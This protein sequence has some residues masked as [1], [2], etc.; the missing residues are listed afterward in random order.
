MRE[1]PK[2]SLVDTVVDGRYHVRS[3]LASGGMSTVYLATDERLER[4]VALKVLYPHLAEDERFLE[5][6]EREAKSAA[7]LSHPH[8]VGVLD[9]GVEDGPGQSVAY[10]VMEYVP[11]KTL[12][13]LLTERGR[14]TPR[15]ALAILDPVV[16]GLGAAHDAGLIH[17]DVK[18]ENVLLSERGGIKIADFGLARA[19]SAA[20]HT[21]TLVGTA[22]YFPPE[23]VT[24]GAADAR[25]DIYSAGI[26]LFEL[27][28]GRQPYSGEAP[29]QVAFQH[30][31]S[32]VPA[33]STIVPGLAEDL[34]ELVLWC[35]A[36]D[37]EERPIDGNALLGELRHI[38]TNLRDD[39]LD[40][41][42]DHRAGS[43]P[44]GGEAAASDGA[45]R[46]EIIGTAH[47]STDVAGSHPYPTEVIG[48]SGS[49]TTVLGNSSHHTTV[50]GSTPVAGS[51]PQ[52]QLDSAA[53]EKL[54]ARDFKTYRKEQARA[55]QRPEKTLRP[56][57]AR[58]RNAFLI[59]LL[60]LL[61]ALAAI[62]GWFFGVGPGALVAVPDVSSRSVSAAQAL[63]AQ[64]GLSSS[65][66]QSY[67]DSV[68]EGLVIASEPE[69]TATVRPWE[70]IQLLVSLGPELF[71]IPEVVGLAEATAAAT[72]VAAGFEV[73]EVTPQFSDT[74]ADGA[75]IATTPAAG[76]QVPAGTPVSLTVSRGP[77]PVSV[78][79]VVG[80][81]EEEAVSILASAGLTPVIEPAPVNDINVPAGSV[82][83][84]T[85][86]EGQLPPGGSVT[87]TL[88]DGPRIIAVPDVFS[89]REAEAI[90]ALE[91][92]GFT[93]KVNYAFGRPVLGLVAGQDL[94]GE[95]PEG[96]TVTI[97]VT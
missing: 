90:A 80:L 35:T 95:H 84:Q 6:F 46:T 54:A 36:V 94:T 33:P 77:E 82:L 22:A 61:A 89:E 52:R 76:E 72:L 60:A 20:T 32:R 28:T 68:A 85:P 13:D 97:T 4:D 16:E 45:E 18:P 23:L 5:R 19:V 58:R 83:A 62:A 71:A 17:R 40:H 15:Q 29:I 43:A 26:V 79:S 59:L 1:R 87:L 44:G 11:G 67:S 7:R 37:P 38:R 14:L 65:A 93:V 27:L 66:E 42:S 56:G 3:R 73:G 41:G 53:R 25:S 51:M 12:R 91:E 39:E 9:Q 86:A 8:V 55:V 31:N 78:P 24:G 74:V 21:G 48:A 92:A 49:P 88:S 75:V 10:L 50:L 96:S 47:S 57:N 69:A 70:E 34:D 30:V 63:L 81:P 2:D 64:A